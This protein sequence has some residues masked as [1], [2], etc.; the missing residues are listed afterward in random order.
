MERLAIVVPCYNEQEVL[1]DTTQQLTALLLDLIARKIVSENS[2][3]LF[4]NDG[5]KD[6]TWD[7]MQT[8]FEHN[9]LVDVVNLAGNVGHQNALLAGLTTVSERCDI[10]ITIDADLQDDIGVMEEMI[11]KYKAGADIVYGVRK[12]RKTDTFF[13]RFTAQSFYKVMSLLEV[14]TVYNHADYRLMSARAIHQLLQYKE[15]NLF[16]R[17]IVPLIGYKSD[18]VYYSRKARMAGES[19]YP[20]KKMISF[21]FEGITS[22]SVKPIT[23]VLMA[24]AAIMLCSL[25]AYVYILASYFSGRTVSGWSSIMVSIWFLGGLQLLAIGIIGEYIGK[26][27]LEVKERPRFNVEEFLS[28]DQD[29]SKP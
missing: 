22:F 23:M 16:V 13:K 7:L 18:K 9:R 24:G 20:L 21:A 4:V 19:K 5:S 10:A 14:N 28:H 1:P 15:R 12:E 17:G 3:I 8:A 6:R 29:E 25:I 11:E 26:T 27:Y 2:Y